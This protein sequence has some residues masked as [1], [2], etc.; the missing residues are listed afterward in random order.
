MK[1]NV[2]DAHTGHRPVS[3][4]SSQSR[5]KRAVLSCT[6]LKSPIWLTVECS[7]MT[8]L[9]ATGERAIDAA[10]TAA[11]SHRLRPRG[12]LPEP[13]VYYKRSIQC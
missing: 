4:A 2:S 5:H 10:F 9:I 1:A 13:E 8:I 11:R 12:W 3:W 6:W 7:A